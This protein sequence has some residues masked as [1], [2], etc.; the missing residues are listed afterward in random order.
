MYCGDIEVKLIN[1]RDYLQ[2]IF[3]DF[4]HTNETTLMAIT[5]M[6]ATATAMATSTTNMTM[7]PMMLLVSSIMKRIANE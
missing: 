5:M 4:W 6:T 2:W 7:P 3:I 1:L